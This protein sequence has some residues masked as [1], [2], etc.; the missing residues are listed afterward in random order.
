MAKPTSH[1]DWAVGNPN[2][3]LNIIE[4][5]SAKKISAWAADERP[6]YEFMN[7]LFFRQDEWNKYFESQTDS[8]AGKYPVVIGSGADA[9]HATLQAAVNDV[10]LGTDLW[11][12]VKEGEALN[13]AISLTKA[14]WRIDIAPGVVYSKG[15]GAP[16]S[17]FS[18]EAEGIEINYGR[19]TGW[20]GGSDV[21]ILQNAAAEYAK[22][23]GCR[24]G[25]STNSEVD[26][27]A[28]PAGKKGPITDT[29]SEV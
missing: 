9:T 23:F 26:Q 5:S 2:P 20:T 16:T 1:L 13:T 4:P 6:P 28:V 24:F 10:A 21:V 18:V 19:F 3:S 22:V 14:R 27:S 8:F 7:W 29:I 17:A 12:L 15:G 25:A 11:V